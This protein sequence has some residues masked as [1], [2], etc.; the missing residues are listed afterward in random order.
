[1]RVSAPHAFFYDTNRHFLEYLPAFCA[2]AGAG[3]ARVV[4]VA[5]RVL[6]KVRAPRAA[7]V[8]AGAAAAL[9]L[10]TSIVWPIAEYHPFEVTYFNVF[11][12]GLGGAQRRGLLSETGPLKRACQAEADYWYTGSRL[13]LADLQRVAKPTDNLFIDGPTPPQ[14]LANW[15]AG[16]KLDAP[17]AYRSEAEAEIVY[18][19]PSPGVPWKHI[20]EIER[21]RPVLRRVERGTGLIYEILGPKDG[22]A[23]EPVSPRSWYDVQP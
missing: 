10:A 11:A 7:V 13:G 23:H 14:A 18:I 6:A 5:S 17:A 9:A 16:A 21:E 12:G 2:M 15:P 1:L 8:A 22:K 3:A 4:E 20:H 19:S